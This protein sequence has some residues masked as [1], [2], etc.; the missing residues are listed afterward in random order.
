MGGNGAFVCCG[1]RKVYRLFPDTSVGPLARHASNDLLAWE[2]RSVS[3]VEKSA[4]ECS[5]GL[6]GSEE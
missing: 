4:E 5:N 1:Q 6:V 2:H 3:S